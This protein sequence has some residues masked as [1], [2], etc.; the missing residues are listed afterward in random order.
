MA[1]QKYVA[2]ELTHF[3]GRGLTTMEE[4][5]RLL[6]EIVRTGWLRPSYRGE[7]G[8]GTIMRVDP[9]KPLTSNECV[10]AAALCFCDIPFDDLGIHME[11]Y[12]PFGLA[13]GKRFMLS[14]GASPV[15]Y[16]AKNAAVPTSP[17]IGPK[18]LGD[19]F[20]LL[21]DELA[22]ICV[23]VD[24]YAYRRNPTGTSGLRFTSKLS[25][26]GTPEELRM[27]GKLNAFAS[28]LDQMV[29]AH[30]KSF[31]G[32]LAEDHLEN[33][34]MEREWRKMDGLAFRLED[35][36]RIILPLPFVSRLHREFPTYGGLINAQN[37]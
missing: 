12:S 6:V 13:F 37:P 28:D 33:F 14:R 18:T 31:D 11:K 22:A 15:F 25:S 35:V 29:F 34:Y 36:H 9:S 2:T 26:I 30:L 1:K 10:R 16:V 5:F 4:Q 23:S 24:E 8:A 32:L 20:Q 3:V 17:G 27:L 19:K 7:F 21:R